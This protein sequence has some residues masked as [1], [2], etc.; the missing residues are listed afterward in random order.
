MVENVNNHV[1]IIQKDPAPL[2][3]PFD[4]QRVQALLPQFFFY[5][6]GDR[7]DLAVGISAANHEI[8]SKRGDSLHI[9][10][11]QVNGLVV[12]GSP[13]AEE[14]FLFRSWGY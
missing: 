4:A 12:Q 2:T 14:G 10:D 5:M 3:L 9:Q 11:D 1:P 7:L 13:G 8:I 6:G